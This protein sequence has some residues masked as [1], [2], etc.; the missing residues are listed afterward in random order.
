MTM[1]CHIPHLK[2]KGTVFVFNK[3]NQSTRVHSVSVS[4]VS[5]SAHLR[6]Q[7]SM[8]VLPFVYTCCVFVLNVKALY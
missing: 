5:S 2:Q 1:K 8:L 3:E 4:V 6:S 7:V